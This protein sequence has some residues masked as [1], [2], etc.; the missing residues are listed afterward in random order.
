MG[1]LLALAVLLAIG[2]VLWWVCHEGSRSIADSRDRRRRE[3]QLQPMT[4]AAVMQMLAEA[5]RQADSSA[6][7]RQTP[8]RKEGR[9]LWRRLTELFSRR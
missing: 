7:G 4:Y 3:V 5:R 8:G 9:R 6:T 2:G 1:A